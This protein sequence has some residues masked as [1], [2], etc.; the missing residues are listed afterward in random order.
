MVALN[1]VMILAS[2]LK[3]APNSAK[4]L[5]VSPTLGIPKAATVRAPS[6]AMAP[7]MLTYPEASLLV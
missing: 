6:E 1:A 4:S 7:V 3:A 5:S 2:H